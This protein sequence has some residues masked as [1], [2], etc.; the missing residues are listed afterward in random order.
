MPYDPLPD[1]YRRLPSV[2]ELPGLTVNESL[3]CLSGLIAKL[4]HDQTGS[5]RDLV[6]QANHCMHVMALCLQAAP[7][8]H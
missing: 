5:T 7:S 4:E 8:A 3:A 2:V 1:Y 6:S